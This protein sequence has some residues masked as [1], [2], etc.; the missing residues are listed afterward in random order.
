MTL[1]SFGVT[2]ALATGISLLFARYVSNHRHRVLIVGSVVMWASAML[3]ATSKA[4]VSQNR[5]ETTKASAEKQI[6]NRPIEVQGDGYVS[7]HTCRTCHQHN[8]D[9]WYDSYHRTMTQGATT[10][11]V[12]GEF[13]GRGSREGDAQLL[14]PLVTGVRAAIQIDLGLAAP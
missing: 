3:A 12:F 11:T 13:D 14:A 8:Y 2:A 1:L 10:K 6:T 4:P 5:A 7:S 9:T